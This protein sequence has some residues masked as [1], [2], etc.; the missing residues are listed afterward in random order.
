MANR[1]HDPFDLE[2]FIPISDAEK[3]HFKELDKFFSF[4]TTRYYLSLVEKKNPNCPIRL[5]ILPRKEE[6]N[7]SEYEKK[8]PLAEESHMPVKGVTHRY[9]DRA[10]WYLSH[11]CAV[12]CRFCTRKRK[13]GN[14]SETPRSEDIEEALEYFYKHSEIKE[15]ILSGGDPLSLSD[16]RI[17]FIIQELKK[18]THLNHIRIHTRYPVTNPFRLTE[19][20]CERLKEF[21]PLYLVTHFNTHKE[22]TSEAALGIRNLI[23]KGNVIVLNQTVLMKGINDSAEDLR[24][25]NYSLIQMGVKPYYLHQCDEVFGSE[26]FRVPIEKGIAIMKK[27]RGFMSGIT[28]PT[29]VADL[30]GGGGKVPLPTDYLIKTDLETYTFQN[31]SG[32]EFKISK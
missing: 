15:V 23:Q 25:L 13:V 11:N 21:F 12:F 19:N 18:I 27:L 32:K 5:Q 29:Y 14:S 31:Y 7:H 10:L 22:C 1:I 26:H 6:L 16:D 17:I 24:D 8:D 28:I 3:K 30:T 20:F 2:N 9:P 4:G